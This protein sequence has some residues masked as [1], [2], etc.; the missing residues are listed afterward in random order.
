M[1]HIRHLGLPTLE[2]LSKLGLVEEEV[3]DKLRLNLPRR[4]IDL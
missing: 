3:I 4:L 1:V 2:P